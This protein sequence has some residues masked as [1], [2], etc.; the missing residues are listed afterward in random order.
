MTELKI[1]RNERNF[2]LEF[3]KNYLESLFELTSMQLR[4][5]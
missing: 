2:Q 4:K 5:A 3:D 1:S